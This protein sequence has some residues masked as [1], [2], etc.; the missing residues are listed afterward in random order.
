[1]IEGERFRRIRSSLERP[2]TLIELHFLESIVQIFEKFLTFMQREEPLIHVLHE[3]MCG[4]LIGIMRRFLKPECIPSSLGSD[5]KEIDSK[6]SENQLQDIDTGEITKEKIK[7]S[8]ISHLPKMRL[9]LQT[10]CQYLQHKLP[11]ANQLLSASKCLLPQNRKNAESLHAVKILGRTSKDMNL[12]LLAD[13]WRC[14]QAEEIPEDWHTIDEKPVRIDSFWRNIFQIKNAIGEQKYPNIEKIVKTVLILS[15]GNSDVERSFSVAKNQV[16]NSRSTLSQESIN[17]L[18]AARDGL[19]LQGNKPEE[20]CIAQEFLR[21]GRSAH[22]RYQCRIEEEKRQADLQRQRK[23]D[24][25]RKMKELRKKAD[26]MTAHNEKSR[27]AEKELNKAE[28]KQRDDFEVGDRLLEQGAERL[29]IALEKKDMKEVA[30]AQAMIEA[31]QKKIHDVK[32]DLDA[33]RKAQKKIEKRK[34]SLIDSFVS[35]KKSKQN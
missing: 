23:D 22:A 6:A 29:K 7:S 35:S 34:Q 24:E 31:A 10:I 25:D 2:D 3:Q 32:G 28:S 4:L 20:V 14:Y 19:K 5:L 27:S 30:L 15:H 1:M 13:E 9:F 8:N 16:P 12:D 11:L 33:T 18:R 26:E 21:L 17:G